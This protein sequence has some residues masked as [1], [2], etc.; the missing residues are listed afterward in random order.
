MKKSLVSTRLIVLMLLTVPAS[1]I[2]AADAIKT[3]S[4]IQ[5]PIVSGKDLAERYY[6]G[7]PTEAVRFRFCQEACPASGYLAAFP[8]FHQT[9][10]DGNHV[11]GALCFKADQAKLYEVSLDLVE[12]FDHLPALFRAIHTNAQKVGMA[13]GYPTFVSRQQQAGWVLQCV[14][15]PLENVEIRNLSVSQLAPAG[16]G[17]VPSLFRAI[18]DYAVKN[19]FEGGY[20]TFAPSSEDRPSS[21]YD[22]VLIKKG[23][24]DRHD[25]ISNWKKA[26]IGW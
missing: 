25:F 15:L 1:T 10:T 20:P 21:G 14:F 22:C 6:Q 12:A 11:I 16:P 18:H 19:G 3:N 2:P 17:D 24:A 4:P 5:K 23:R 13:S 8:N 7:E 26:A 9:L